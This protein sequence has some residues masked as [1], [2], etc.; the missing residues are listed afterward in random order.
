[1]WERVKVK[2]SQSRPQILVQT[3]IDFLVQFKW[4]AEDNDVFSTK[5]AGFHCIS[6]VR[7]G[8]DTRKTAYMSAQFAPKVLDTSFGSKPTKT[9]Q[10]DSKPTCNS[11]EFNLG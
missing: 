5:I 3:I 4:V 8:I 11:S 6:I 10:T 7:L 2:L 1:M 9:T